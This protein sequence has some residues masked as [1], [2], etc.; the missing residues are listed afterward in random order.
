MVENKKR[1]SRSQLVF[2]EQSRVV[3]DLSEKQ[4]FSLYKKAKQANIPFHI[5]EEVYR[6]G[7][8]AH[9]TIMKDPYPDHDVLNNTSEQYA[10]NRVNSFLASGQAASLDHDLVEKYTGAEDISQNSDH[11]SSRFEG[12]DQLT[13]IYRQMTPGQVLKTIKKVIRQKNK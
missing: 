13:K 5:I 12:S 3:V 4:L 6:R 2:A 8:S 11:P 9:C 1:L 7:V 10:F